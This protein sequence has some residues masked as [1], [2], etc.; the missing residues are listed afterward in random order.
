MKKQTWLSILKRLVSLDSAWMWL[1]SKGE[2]WISVFV[3]IRLVFTH[4]VPYFFPFFYSCRESLPYLEFST[5]YCSSFA[6]YT[7]ACMYSNKR[8][9][10]R[11][12]IMKF[13]IIWLK[14]GWFGV[15]AT[16]FNIHRLPIYKL[17]PSFLSQ[18]Y[19]YSCVLHTLVRTYQ[20]LYDFPYQKRR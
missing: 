8:S 15:L 16:I 14:N 17:S 10:W 19:S 11:Q 9:K 4:I 6:L 12:F 1:L 3:V 2:K 13:T 20:N 18:Y 7:H 5:F